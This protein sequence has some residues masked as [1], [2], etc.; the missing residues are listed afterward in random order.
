MVSKLWVYH[1]RGVHLFLIDRMCVCGHYYY[2]VTLVSS[3][4]LLHDT[5]RVR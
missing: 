4:Y 3:R 2:H 5:P 1:A